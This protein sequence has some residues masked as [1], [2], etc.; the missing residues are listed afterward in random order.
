MQTEIQT[1]LCQQSNYRQVN[2]FG[3]CSNGVPGLNIIGLSHLGRTVKEKFIFL[4]RERQ[5]Q[6]PLKKYVICV[7]QNDLKD[8]HSKS[9]LKWLEL[10]MLLIFWSLADVI[11]I[12][13]MSN[14]LASGYVLSNGT[15]VH[16]QIPIEFSENLGKRKIITNICDGRDGVIKE[17][18]NFKSV[19][20]SEDLLQDIP[21][22]TLI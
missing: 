7:E 12:R 19:I 15:I 22:L 8:K 16:N 18:L 6:L 4:T 1:F 14:C 2:I 21:N 13:N 20:S 17:N 11:P 9:E 5:I 3:Y 10:P